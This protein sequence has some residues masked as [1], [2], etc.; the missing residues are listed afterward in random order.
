MLTDVY[1]FTTVKCSC[2]FTFLGNFT[3][4][5]ILLRE[6]SCNRKIPGSF[7]GLPLL[8]SYFQLIQI[9]SEI[10]IHSS[11]DTAIEYLRHQRKVY[12]L[13]YLY[14]ILNPQ[15]YVFLFTPKPTVNS[16]TCW[17]FA[18]NAISE[19]CI[20]YLVEPLRRQLL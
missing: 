20:W 16:E 19:T 3:T 5:Q 4:G 10:R 17:E 6:D 18:P 8:T 11:L 1:Q 2:V 7:L 12:S 9:R 13:Q 15:S 14:S